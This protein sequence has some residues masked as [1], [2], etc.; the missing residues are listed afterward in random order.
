MKRKLR[1]LGQLAIKKTRRTEEKQRARKEINEVVSAAQEIIFSATTVF[2]FTFFPDTIAISRTKLSI[3]RRTFFMVSDVVSIK[4]EDILNVTPHLG[5][6][7]GSLEIHTRFFDP[8]KP[9]TINYLW[10]Q[11]AL[12]VDRILHGYNIALEKKIDTDA[13]SCKE[14]ATMLDKLGREAAG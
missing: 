13:L 4:L 9:Y 8:K 2:P 10:R 5:P 7:F 1:E 3:T 14:L 12:K 6:L 11:D